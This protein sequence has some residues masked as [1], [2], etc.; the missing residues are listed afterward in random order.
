MLILS[1]WGSQGNIFLG[2]KGAR[3]VKRDATSNLC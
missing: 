2:G 3:K 1:A